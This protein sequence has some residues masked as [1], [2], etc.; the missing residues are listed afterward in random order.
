MEEN[1]VK[2]SNKMFKNKLLYL[3]LAIACFIG[4]ILIFF[5]DGYVGLYDTLT[6]S[7]G[8]QSQSITFAQMS[9]S[10]RDGYAPQ[11]YPNN[12]GNV[13]LNYEID[14]RHFSAYQSDIVVSIWH[15]QV[16]VADIFTGTVD[17]GAFKKDAVTWNIDTRD[18]ISQDA[19]DGISYTLEIKRGDILRKV[20]FFV[21]IN[22]IKT[23]APPPTN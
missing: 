22:N 11:L 23:F 4:I 17:V 5:F 20:I 21:P 15:N 1:A 2:V 16:K 8:E 6:M 9:N 18:Y 10:T 12:S 3:I 7:S 19:N 13:S 14:N